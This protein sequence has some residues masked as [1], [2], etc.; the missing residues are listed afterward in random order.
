[1]S[2]LTQWLQKHG[3]R[4]TAQARGECVTDCGIDFVEPDSEMD[5]FLHVEVEGNRVRFSD[6]YGWDDAF[7]LD[8]VRKWIQANG[9]LA[10]WESFEKFNEQCPDLHSLADMKGGEGV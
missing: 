2:E 7:D 9:R 3:M 5:E 4:S 8:T 6:A 1:M 10:T